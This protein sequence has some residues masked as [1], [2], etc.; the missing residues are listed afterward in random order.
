VSFCAKRRVPAVF[1]EPSFIKSVVGVVCVVCKAK[2][3]YGRERIARWFD[4]MLSRNGFTVGIF[5]NVAAQRDRTLVIRFACGNKQETLKSELWFYCPCCCSENKSNDADRE[6][7]A[8]AANDRSKLH[9]TQVV[10]S[11]RAASACLTGVKT[12]RHGKGL[13]NNL[14][15]GRQAAPL[16]KEQ[17]GFQ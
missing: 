17:H 5:V 9:R 11:F 2:W 10:H 1:S 14:S 4:R 12:R 15:W 8:Q 7:P 6:S 16:N 3:A 13:I